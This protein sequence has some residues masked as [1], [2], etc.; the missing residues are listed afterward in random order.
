MTYESVFIGFLRNSF[1]DPAFTIGLQR[2]LWQ[3]PL[4]DDWAINLDYRLG[5]LT[6]YD[7]QLGDSNFFK[8]TPVTPFVQLM[9]QL[10]YD[11]FGIE[12]SW[13]IS[14]VSVQLLYRF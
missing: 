13:A 9:T 1:A 10:T 11:N 3:K 8:Y 12:L 6:G 4:N 7:Q 5:V 2:T 14:V